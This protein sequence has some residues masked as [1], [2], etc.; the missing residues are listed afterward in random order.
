ML[1]SGVLFGLGYKLTKK[2]VDEMAAAIEAKEV[3]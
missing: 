2:D 1:A 3:K